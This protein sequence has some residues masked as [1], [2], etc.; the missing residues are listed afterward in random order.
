MA[1]QCA[2][3]SLKTPLNAAHQGSESSVDVTRGSVHFWGEG[4]DGR[5]TTGPGQL[6]LILGGLCLAQGIPPSHPHV[7]S[8]HRLS[9]PLKATG[10]GSFPALSL[11]TSCL[12]FRS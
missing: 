4:K 12:P 6:A 8:R 3:M 2:H 5:I 11:L 9:S 1:G 7:Q 10:L